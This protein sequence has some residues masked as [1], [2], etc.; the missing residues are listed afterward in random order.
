MS[1]VITSPDAEFYG[2]IVSNGK[3][4]F[5]NK[6]VGLLFSSREFSVIRKIVKLA[7]SLDFE[8]EEDIL[9]KE[10]DRVAVEFSG[11][12]DVPKFDEIR[13]TVLYKYSSSQKR[14]FLRGIYLGCGILSTPPSYHLE[15]RFEKPD[16]LE[17]VKKLLSEFAIKN[18]ER[19]NIIYIAGRENVKQFIYIV[20]AE[21]TYMLMEEDAVNK[22]ILNDTNRKLNFEFANLERQSK[23]ALRQVNILKKMEEEGLLDKLSDRMKEVALLRLQYPYLS[24]SELSEKSHNRLSKQAIYYRL[25]K[26]TDGFK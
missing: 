6:G 24:L 10:K 9:Q 2:L 20:E 13:N 4:V 3:I 14:S 15:F 19:N 25:K 5:A 22:K 23:A 1:R 7:N 11:I 12:K 8:R 17:L 26:I 18:S 16:E 21:K